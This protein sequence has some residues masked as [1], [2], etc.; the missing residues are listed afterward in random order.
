MN[1]RDGFQQ[2]KRYRTA[3]FHQSAGQ[4]LDAYALLNRSPGGATVFIIADV[5]D[6]TIL[7]SRALPD[8]ENSIDSNQTLLD[9]PLEILSLMNRRLCKDPLTSFATVVVAMIDHE[10]DRLVVSNAGGHPALIRSHDGDLV[11]LG[12]E[13]IG[14]P[15]GIASACSWEVTEATLE[16]GD[17]VLILG[18]GMVSAFDTRD[19]Q[20]GLNII[21]EVLKQVGDANEIAEQL[22]K[23]LESHTAPDAIDCDRVFAV[24]ERLQ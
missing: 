20:E 11:E 12:T 24:I 6:Q 16:V 23:M 10:R 14:L 5:A 7:P 21:C 13:G 22:G 2:H 3:R 1:T 9:A 15:L 18:A 8:F 17:S 4:D 19:E